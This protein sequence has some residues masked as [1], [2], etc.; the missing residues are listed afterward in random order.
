MVSGYLAIA[1]S[2]DTQEREE[3]KMLKT[4]PSMG[5]KRRKERAITGK[6]IWSQ[7]SWSDSG[8]NIL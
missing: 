8:K 1:G 5:P 3:V 7:W 4:A 6:G 2:E